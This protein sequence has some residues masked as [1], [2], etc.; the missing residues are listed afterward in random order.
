MR[1]VSLHFAAGS[2]IGVYIGA[3]VGRDI[4]LN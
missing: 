4:G 3:G 1:A 2:G